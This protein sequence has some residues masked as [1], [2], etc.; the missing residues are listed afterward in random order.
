MGVVGAITP[1]NFPLA[2][3]VLKVA[4]AVACGNVVIAKPAEQT[5]LTALYFGSLITEV[6][7]DSRFDAVVTELTFQ[8]HFP[9]YISLLWVLKG[10]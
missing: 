2:L 5:P 4:P 10:D 8:S 7:L 6:C 1:W 3:L 9:G